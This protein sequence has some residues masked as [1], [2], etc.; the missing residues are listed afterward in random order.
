[1]N[2]LFW[3]I[4][5]I[6]LF[7]LI[8]WWSK[9]LIHNRYILENLSNI[10][11]TNHTVDIPLTTTIGCENKCMPPSRCSL[12]GEQCFSDIDCQGCS[13]NDSSIKK[14]KY[15]RGQNDAGKLTT[16]ENPTYST[17]TTDIGTN[18]TLIGNKNIKPVQYFQ[19]INTWRKA[20]DQA[21]E[22]YDKRY[23]PNAQSFSPKYPERISLSGQF[24][25]NGPLPANDFL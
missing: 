21:Q 1:M 12:T 19:G 15:I 6:I 14:T 16:E 25:D 13:K 3:W 24:I 10:G 4:I 22:L 9:Y 23:T 8:I 11:S 20:F 17:L 2:I 7:I 5:I 18:A